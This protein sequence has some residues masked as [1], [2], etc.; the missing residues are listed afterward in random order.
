MAVRPVR[1][2]LLPLACA[3]LVLLA[4][5]ADP[6][7]GGAPAAPSAR[8]WPFLR[9][10]VRA[11]DDLGLHFDQG[12][13]VAEV[14]EGSPARHGRLR[15]GESI[16]A[17]DGAPVASWEDLV[18]ALGRAPARSDFTLTIT[19]VNGRPREASVDLLK[20]ISPPFA[21]CRSRIRRPLDL[22]LILEGTGLEVARVLPRSPVAGKVKPG[23][24]ILAI[25]GRDAAD[26]AGFVAALAGSLPVHLTIALRVERE[27][28]PREIEIRLSERASSGGSGGTSGEH[29]TVVGGIARRY[30]IRGR[31]T[32]DAP[33]PLVVLLHGTNSSTG[34]MFH[35]WEPVAGREALLAAPWGNRNWN[36]GQEANDDA[37]VMKMVDEIL[38]GF[39][40]DLARIY[41]T[42]HSRGA[43]Y[44]FEWGVER[45][46]LFAAAGMFAG[47]RAATDGASD[48]RC[49]FIQYH[50]ELDR[51]VPCA[52]GRQ[53]EEALKA[54]GHAV[55][56][57]MEPGG[58]ADP[59]HHEMV[60][61]GIRAIWE[62]FKAHPM[63]P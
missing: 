1:K 47:G 63:Q 62:F 11:P 5:R 43:Y 50:G 10:D 13:R 34:Y 42:G 8:A 38:A 15:R 56:F 21:R 41:V 29:T 6:P 36:D 61:Q 7:R 25:Q 55:E 31:V 33:L 28:A 22:G 26:A 59:D 48:R 44:T 17:C 57:I 49:P 32:G 23:D 37:F 16:A 54:A 12:L 9:G 35:N 18:V 52:S 53:A 46:D 45:G 19:A 4:A 14:A 58:T 27:G 3:T 60:P 39:D 20:G 24:R 30:E 51:S 2:A 40:I